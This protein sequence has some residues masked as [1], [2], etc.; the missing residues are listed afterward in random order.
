MCIRDRSAT[1][2]SGVAS[3]TGY[4][5]AASATGASGVASA[6][7]DSGAASA[8][9]TRGA[10]SATGDS[11][12]ASATGTRGAASAT[13]YSGFAFGSRCR[14]GRNGAFVVRWYDGTRYQFAFGRVGEN[15]IKSDTW[16]IVRDGEL[17]EEKP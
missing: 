2:D 14:A 9:G 17:T 3:A 4:R 12:A 1:G 7:G 10:A 15:G 11:G 16:Y 8:T 6:T 5:G 13:G